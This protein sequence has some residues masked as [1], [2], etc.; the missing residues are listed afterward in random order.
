MVCILE[1]LF[2]LLRVGSSPTTTVYVLGV[3]NL[4][5]NLSLSSVLYTPDFPFNLLSVSKLTKLLNY[6]AIF[7]LSTHCIF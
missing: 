6:V 1:M 2:H 7:Y 4:S 5:P 3:V